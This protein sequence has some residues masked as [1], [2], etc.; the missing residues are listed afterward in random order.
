M[1]K[2]EEY[3][4]RIITIHKSLGITDLY[5]DIFKI[6]VLREENV[7]NLK[8]I[9]LDIYGREQFMEKNAASYWKSMKEAAY[10]E[11]IELEVVSAFRSVDYQVEII[12]RKIMN[13]IPLIEI[14]KSNAAPGYSEHHTGKALDIVSSSHKE[15]TID[16]ER[17]LEFM[18]LCEN[19]IKFSFFLSYP[20]ECKSKIT[21]EPWHW[22]YIDNNQ[23][24]VK[25]IDLG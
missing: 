10:N 6:E 23:D 12:S 25:P 2:S 15:L 19:A 17:T 1:S 20:R 18:W 16:F 9:G 8:S 13:G 21:Y 7:E 5:E 11:G 22:S 4:N 24:I 3:K 14:L